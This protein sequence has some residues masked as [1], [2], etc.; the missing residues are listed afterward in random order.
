M[1]KTMKRYYWT[2]GEIDLDSENY[3]AIDAEIENYGV[4][5][6]D[7]EKCVGIDFDTENYAHR[8]LGDRY[9]G[10]SPKASSW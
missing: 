5:D 2:Y 4:I 7:I 3:G 10:T 8:R 1:L 9:A 6:T